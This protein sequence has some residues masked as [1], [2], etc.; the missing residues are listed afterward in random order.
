MTIPVNKILILF[1]HPRFEKSR[2]NRALLENI[3]HISGVT[4]HDLYEEYPD[5]NI[6]VELEKRLLTSHQIIIWHHPFHMYGAPA[7]LKQWMDM[8]IRDIYRESFDTSVRLGID[9]LVK[10]GYR[11]YSAYRAGQNFTRY[12][13]AA[14][15]K[16]APHRYD[17]RSYIFNAKEQ[18]QLQEQLLT[19]D[20][21]A[22][23]T[24]NDHAWDSDLFINPA[25]D[26]RPA[27]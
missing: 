19:N 9:V 18:I 1:A 14:M 11:R 13:E 7:L 2:V 26:D 17:E 22:N 27:R 25:A 12:D 24:R 23:P 21:E 4:L 5:F 3:E 10:L 6:D 16:L 20:R 15:H 8:G